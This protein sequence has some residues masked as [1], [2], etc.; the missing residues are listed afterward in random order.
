MTA[1]D[2]IEE[3]LQKSFHPEL[4]EV[5]DE[6][7][8]HAGHSEALKSE[9]GHFNVQIISSYFAGLRLLERHRMIYE[10]LKPLNR[11]IHALSITA[12]APGEK[13]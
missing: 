8:D 4:L 10:A 1:K 2:K 9:G 3:I 5:E 12:L 7:R 13:K 6:S 11:S